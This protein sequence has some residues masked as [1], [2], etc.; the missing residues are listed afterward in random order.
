MRIDV[1]GEAVEL[2]PTKNI[3]WSR[4]SLI[5]LADLHL[6]RAAAFQRSGLAMPEG[7]DDDDLA[8]LRRI[9]AERRPKIAVLLGDIFHSRLAIG[10]SALAGL[11]EAL[12]PVEKVVAI[13]G[14]HDVGVL[15]AFADVGRAFDFQNE[16]RLGPFGFCHDD[17]RLDSKSAEDPNFWWTGHRHPRVTLRIGPDALKLPAF[18]IKKGNGILPAFSSAA[19]GAD[20]AKRE[21]ARRYACAG[22]SVIDL[23]QAFDRD[24]ESMANPR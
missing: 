5:A 7:A 13:V 20:V 18:V 21:N 16:F 14:N 15:R 8:A 17:S 4:E 23:D 24:G 19:A 9:V 6:G 1:R 10:A 22:N 2:D 3:Y 11:R 12:A